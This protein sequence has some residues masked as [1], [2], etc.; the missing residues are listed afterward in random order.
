MQGFRDETGLFG[1]FNHPRA[2]HLAYLGL[3][4]LQ[5]RGPD[6]AGLVTS[7]GD[8]LRRVHGDGPVSEAL[9]GAPLDAL[10]GQHAVGQVVRV[11]LALTPR[12]DAGGLGV[13]AIGRTKGGQIAVAMA[14]RLTNGAALRAALK[15]EGAVFSGSTDAEVVVH[16]IARSRQ[17]TLVNRVVDA[18]G[19]VKGAYS[20]LVLTVDRLIAVRDPHGFRPLVRGRV[21]GATVI[22]TED[23]PIRLLGGEIRGEVLPGQLVVVDPSRESALMPFVRRQR[24]AC[25]QE[26][27]QLASADAT[28]FGRAAYT[29]RVAL[30]ERLALDAPCD[31]GDVVVALP[32]AGAALAVGYARG[33]ALPQRDGL[34]ASTNAGR[35]LA[36]PPSDVRDVRAWMRWTPVPAVVEGQRVVLVAPSIDDGHGLLEA[37]RLLR[38]VGA[39]E[40]HL[41]VA[42]PL[43][44]NACAYGV[45]GPTTEELASRRLG[46]AADLGVWLGVESIGALTGVALREV[47]GARADAERAWCDG[48]LGGA[49]PVPPEEETERNQLDLF[50]TPD[51]NQSR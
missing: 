31:R 26:P 39:R 33:V 50:A 17:S 28:V 12:P 46:S 19:Q 16:L 5:E 25:I 30:G 6:G 36:R 14:G 38:E 10:I 7:D 2:A 35:V 1:V 3:H 51:P 22:A 45:A 40:V 27:L 13:P 49:W 42:S 24:A 20:L 32:G 11:P 41:R 47:L 44:Q 23:G 4:G 8:T 21:D 48:C 15:D 43:V 18:L 34:I 9:G 29:Q 37:V